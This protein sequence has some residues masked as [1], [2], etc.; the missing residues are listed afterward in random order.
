MATTQGKHITPT[1]VQHNYLAGTGIDKTISKL[2]GN[3]FAW[4]ASD[5]GEITKIDTKN[6]LI[7]VK[8]K[9]GLIS[10]IDTSDKPA[11]NS[12]SGFFIKNKLE[13]ADG[14]KVGSK[15]K[16]GDILAANSAFFKKDLDGS[17]GFA[18]GRLS[19]IAMMCLP[20]TYEDSA[21]VTEAIADEMSSEIIVEKQVALK[22]NSKLISIVKEGDKV[23]VNDPL[24]IFEEIGD[25]EKD[26]LASIE[27]A[28]QAAEGDSELEHFGRNIIKSKYSGKVTNI[29]VY[30]NC[31]LDSDS[32]E[33][34]LKK[35][36]EEY[37]TQVTNRS[38][39]LKGIKEDDLIEQASI[40]RIDSDKILGN[41]MTGV[42]IV[43]YILHEEKCDIGNKITFF[44][45]CKGVVSEVIPNEL[46]PQ[47]EYRKENQ[48]D[49]IV[50]P[51]SLIS[52]N[53][54]DLLLTGM[55]NKVILEL[56]FQC[57]EDLFGK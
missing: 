43:F 30:Y 27:R 24:I 6:K 37:I 28:T 50:S 12:A 36:V 4:K 53:T 42:L 1:K 29:K 57:I 9:S 45:A 21:P 49:A 5:D 19:K 34:S 41:E 35:Y 32:L 54:P 13:L 16:K 47:S 46:A 26:A 15:F 22:E 2:T 23:N 40:E 7:F 39:A 51:M 56:K 52:R 25:S 33:P 10:A 3:D 20:T 55:I 8:Y 31:K 44:S 14:Y 38:N 48:I 11:K 18:A 17:H